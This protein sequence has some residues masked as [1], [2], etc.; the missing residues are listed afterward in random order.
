M[1]QT[2]VYNL[3]EAEQKVDELHLC[4]G[5]FFDGTLNS[6]ENTRIRKAVAENK[7]KDW[8]KKLYKE[9]GGKATD[10]VSFQ[11]DYTNVA[12]MQMECF[13]DYAIYIEGIGTVS[14]P[15]DMDNL[16]KRNKA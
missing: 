13:E 6:K 8:E 7:A 5:L 10:N 2:F 11:N 14:I 15:D 4:F 16:S 12:R 9:H 3:G 1:S